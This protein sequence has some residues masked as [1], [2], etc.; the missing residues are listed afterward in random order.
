M[1]EGE[2]GSIRKSV[3]SLVSSET[4]GM[5]MELESPLSDEDFTLK[6][7]RCAFLGG[8]DMLAHLWLEEFG[9][10]G[11]IAGR[12]WEEEKCREII[13]KSLMGWDGI[14]IEERD[15]FIMMSFG[16]NAM[17]LIILKMNLHESQA[18]E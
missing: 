5:A 14:C 18:V 17:Y 3:S 6:F 12:T 8:L 1:D 15:G 9:L 13:A 2:I 10:E 7:L 4:G 16:A 11:K